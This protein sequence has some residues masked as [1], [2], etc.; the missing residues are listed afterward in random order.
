[1]KTIE[2]ESTPANAN[3]NAVPVRTVE[4]LEIVWTFD[5]CQVRLERVAVAGMSYQAQG[6]LLIRGEKVCAR[7]FSP[8][9]FK[10]EAGAER[11]ALKWLTRKPV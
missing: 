2:L 7:S 9:L 11:A 6:F 10:T 3:A 8:R 1:M 4:D 5:G